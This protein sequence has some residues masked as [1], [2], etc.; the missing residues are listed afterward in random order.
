MR[1]RDG[2]C[3]GIHHLRALLRT[4]CHLGQ[5]Q[6]R[7]F[8]PVFAAMKAAP[9]PRARRDP[10]PTGSAQH[11]GMARCTT[12][13]PPKTPFLAHKKEWGRRGGEIYPC[14][15]PFNG[16]F[17]GVFPSPP[18]QI[19]P[20]PRQRGPG[21]GGQRSAVRHLTPLAARLG[22]R[23]ISFLS[24]GG[25][26]RWPGGSSCLAATSWLGLSPAGRRGLW[27][28]GGERLWL[29]LCSDMLFSFR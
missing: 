4:S 1:G 16:F 8:L 15:A 29:L 11:G 24:A 17:W 5:N 12:A 28:R 9:L 13:V 22:E 25:S 19:S 10:T 26:A 6:N 14:R 7:R 18:T 23:E 3:K 21:W 27:Q 2:V 20:K